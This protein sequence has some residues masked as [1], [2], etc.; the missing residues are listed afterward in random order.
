MSNELIVLP[1]KAV[2]IKKD[3][4]ALAIITITDDKTNIAASENRDIV[5]KYRKAYVEECEET[6]LKLYQPYEQFL[7]LKKNDLDEID[8]WIEKQ[9]KEL[10]AYAKKILEEANRKIKEENDRR[11]AEAKARFEAEQEERRKENERKAAETK[12]NEEEISFLPPAPEEP[13]PVF[14]PQEAKE[15]TVVKTKGFGSSTS[16]KMK[17]S[18][19]VTNMVTLGNTLLNSGEEEWFRSI[20]GDVNIAKLN[21]FCKA[22]GINGG[23][24]TYPGIHV[25]MVPDIKGR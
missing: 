24:V 20:F 22:K 12:N 6:R 8:E 9:D 19:T 2:A 5:K 23:S 15:V 3:I 18:A 7:A 25:E 10:G 1:P 14:V 11:N 13:A 4:S 17:P 21:A 16:I